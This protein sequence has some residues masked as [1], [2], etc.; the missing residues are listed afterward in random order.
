MK[1]ILALIL[2]VAT[3]V[4]GAFALTSCGDKYDLNF[5]EEFTPLESQMDVLL[6]LN[7][8]SIDV[9]VMRENWTDENTVVLTNKGKFDFSE[10]NFEVSNSVKINSTRGDFKFKNITGEFVNVK[11]TEVLDYD[12]LGEVIV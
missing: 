5:G 4:T 2:T 6:K 12:L 11:I 3:L 8:K 10:Q 1:K 7:A 9:G